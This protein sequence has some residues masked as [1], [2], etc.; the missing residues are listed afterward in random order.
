MY[1]EPQKLF[2]NI[3]ELY[4][5]I[6]H[7]YTVIIQAGLLKLKRRHRIWNGFFEILIILTFFDFAQ[8][9]TGT[10][11]IEFKK[12]SDVTF[13]VYNL[14]TAWKMHQNEYKHAYVWSS[15]S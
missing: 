11:F 8:M 2:A 1:A 4:Q 6:F 3:D 7:Y 9:S 15:S 5:V 10:I 13:Y 12:K 14:V